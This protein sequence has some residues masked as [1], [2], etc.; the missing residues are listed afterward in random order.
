MHN[1]RDSHGH[2]IKHI[3]RYVGGTTNFGLFFKIDVSRSVVGYSDNNHNIDVDDGR[4]TS[5]HAFYYGSSLVTWMSQKQ[6]AVVVSSCKAE[7]MAA[8]ETTKQAIWIKELLC[9]ILSEES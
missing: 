3:L 5:A 7:F 2:A 4:S 8:I 9:E 6:Q 1:P